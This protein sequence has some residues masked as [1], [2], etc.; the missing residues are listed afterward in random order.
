MAQKK[1]SLYIALLIAFI[2]Y[3]GIGLIYPLFSSM[4]FDY[5]HDLLPE[6]TTHMMRGLWLGI[7]I[8]LM[9][10]AQFFSSAFW[11]TLSDKYGRKNPLCISVA[12]G[13]FGY[14][15]ALSGAALS[16]IWLLFLSRIVVGIGSG[17]MSIVQ[18]TIADLSDHE[19]KAQNFSLFS[20]A[21]GAGFTLGPFFGGTLSSWQ[22][23]IPFLFATLMI[24]VNL[25]FVIAFFKETHLPV[26]SKKLSWKI[27]IEHISKAFRFKGIRTIL[28]CSFLHNFGWSYFFE[29]IPVYLIS[30]FMFAPLDLGVFYACA[31]FFYSISS[32]ILLRPLTSRYKPIILFVVGNL[33]SSFAIF[34]FALLPSPIWIWPLLCLLCFFVALVTPASI[35]YVSNCASA[36][37]Q[38]EALGILTSVNAAA[39]ILSPLISGFLVGSY[40]TLPMLVG[41]LSLFAAFFIM[42]CVFRA[43]LLEIGPGLRNYEQ[44]GA[45]P[46]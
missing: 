46:A 3:M 30:H 12:I 19:N 39:Y 42:V 24:F 4:I 5:S 16:S 6:E 36:E 11:G 33:F 23:H 21:I 31:G 9:P 43:R 25:L 41:G 15:L 45:G 20:M 27:G 26:K 37:I 44:N 40:P 38:G 28:L 17:N 8:A 2:D 35:T 29:F 34:A 10:M 32:G 7:L 22:Y 1:A 14:I 13:F 18:A